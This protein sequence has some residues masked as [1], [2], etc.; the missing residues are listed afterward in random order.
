MVFARSV[1]V[2]FMR[3]GAPVLGGAGLPTMPPFFASAPT[4]PVPLASFTG[5][6]CGTV[7]AL[8]TFQHGIPTANNLHLQID[9]VRLSF[10]VDHAPEPA[11]ALLPLDLL[12][13]AYL[14]RRADA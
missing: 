14:R 10:F 12:S 7:W 13:I 5:V 4:A 3:D 11:I 8:C 1:F 9:A 2:Q 6:V